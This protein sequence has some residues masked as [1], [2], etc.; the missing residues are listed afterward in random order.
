MHGRATG[1]LNSVAALSQPQDSGTTTPSGLGLRAAKPHA[2]AE[3][4]TLMLMQPS[5]RWP[6]AG[7]AFPPL[8]GSGVDPCVEQHSAADEDELLI[9]TKQ[10]RR[11]RND[12]ERKPQSQGY[13]LRDPIYVTS[14]KQQ[15]TK[16]RPAGRSLGVEGRDWKGQHQGVGGI[17]G[18]SPE[19]VHVM[20]L[21]CT[22]TQR[23]RAPH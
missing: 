22:D 2:H 6:E 13:M 3:A 19:R 5:S 18:V 20:R 17:A 7:S 4:C 15:E 9:R 8:G 21:S 16:K 10:G 12:A 14:L 11:T 1:A 23:E